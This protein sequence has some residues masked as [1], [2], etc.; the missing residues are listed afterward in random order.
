MRSIGLDIGDRRIGVALSDP[1][2]ILATPLLVFEHSSD[3]GDISFIL[4]LIKQYGVEIMIVGLPHSM[5]GSLGTQA[6]KVQSFTGKLKEESPVPIEYRDERLTTVAAKSMMEQAG[7][8]KSV[9]NKK[10]EYDAA[11]AAIILQ[12]YLNETKPL[13][14]PPIDE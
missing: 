14:Y 8:K 3:A 10:I 9:R 11:A 6:E 2:G 13:E 1:L 12:S 4:Q 5:N 7:S